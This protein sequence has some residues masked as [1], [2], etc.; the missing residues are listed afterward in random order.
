MAT[1]ASDTTAADETNGTTTTTIIDNAGNSD[2]EKNMESAESIAPDFPSLSYGLEV[3]SA[4]NLLDVF[5]SRQKDRHRQ[6][7]IDHITSIQ[8]NITHRGFASLC[9]GFGEPEWHKTHVL[10]CFDQ[11]GYGILQTK[12]ETLIYLT[13]LYPNDEEAFAAY[14][15]TKNNN[16]YRWPMVV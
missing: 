7:M 5:Y 8:R 9:L 11:P 10:E 13:S 16:K 15:E 2:D 4:E 12:S 3:L 6:D 14:K 1:R